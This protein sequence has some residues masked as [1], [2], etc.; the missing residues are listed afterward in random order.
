MRPSLPAL[1]PLV[2]LAALVAGCGGHNPR[3]AREE[4]LAVDEHF[5]AEVASQGLSVFERYYAEDAVE[6]PSFQPIIEGKSAILEFYRPYGNNPSFKLT[7]KP[8][9]AEVSEDGG[10]GFTYGHYEATTADDQGNLVSRVGKYVTIWRREYDGSWKVI[11][12]GGS[13]DDREAPPDAVAPAPPAPEA[14]KPPAR[15]ER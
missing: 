6:M 3:A 1:P 14:K 12:D 15:K 4:L 13:P 2:V 10:L 9:R 7:W 8:S 11:L 5:A